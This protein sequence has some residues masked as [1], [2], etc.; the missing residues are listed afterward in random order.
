MDY[1][2]M[3]EGKY[4]GSWNLIDASGRKLEITVTIESVEAQMIVGE[5]GKRNKKPVIKYEG[6]ELPHVIGK[7]VAK[8]IASLYGNDTKNWIG[9][10]ITIY[11]TTTEVGG[12]TKDCIRVRP[13]IPTNGKSKKEATDA[14]AQ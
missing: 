13:V 14:A 7:T 3:F 1:R 8:T 4:L 12:E 11:G 9:K 2:A 6:K 5:G 10:K